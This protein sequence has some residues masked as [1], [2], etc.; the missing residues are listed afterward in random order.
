MKRKS[1][2]KEMQHKNQT[3]CEYC[4]KTKEGISF[5][6]GASREPAWVMIEGTGSMCCP[7]CWS[8]ARNDGAAAVRK[9]CGLIQE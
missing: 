1:R 7:D 9:H 6:I 8:V 2:I 5:V 4:G 3:I